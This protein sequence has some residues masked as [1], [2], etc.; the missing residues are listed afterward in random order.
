MSLRYLNAAVAFCFDNATTGIIR[1]DKVYLN[2][3]YKGL[4]F[5][6]S[7]LYFTKHP[8]SLSLAVSQLYFTKRPT[9]EVPRKSE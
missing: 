2:N 7:H 4:S 8:K 5:V 1:S 9:K 6:L 3:L